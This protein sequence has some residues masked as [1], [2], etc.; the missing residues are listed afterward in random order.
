MLAEHHYETFIG[1]GVCIFMAH[2]ISAHGLWTYDG[3]TVLIKRFSNFDE[4]ERE[5]FTIHE[6]T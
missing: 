2:G 5:I 1:K 4:L 6:C 3:G